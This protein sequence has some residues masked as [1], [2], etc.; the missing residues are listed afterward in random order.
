MKPPLLWNLKYT[1]ANDLLGELEA[2]RKLYDQ[3]SQKGSAG[4]LAALVK[5]LQVS[6]V[7]A[8]LTVPLAN[9]LC[10]LLDADKWI[11]NP[12]LAVA[13]R[14]NS[15]LRIKLEDRILW[16][17]AAATVTL[18]NKAGMKVNEALSKVARIIGSS[19][20]KTLQNYRKRIQSPKRRHTVSKETV[21]ELRSPYPLRQRCGTTRHDHERMRRALAGRSSKDDA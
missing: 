12:H 10:A 21:R 11:A 2:A 7:E 8:R 20:T 13:K 3:N 9:L 17:V 15:D 18:L 16:G 4:A 14:Q 19:D 5:Y 6:G 1:P